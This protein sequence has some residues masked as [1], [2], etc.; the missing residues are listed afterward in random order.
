MS[1]DE[2]GWLMDGAEMLWGNFITGVSGWVRNG[3][4]RKTFEILRE[5]SRRSSL[6]S[7]FFSHVRVG[8]EL[9]K[10]YPA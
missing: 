2:R 8:T 9:K 5:A 7:Y 6:S 10:R 4:F 1:E 3:P